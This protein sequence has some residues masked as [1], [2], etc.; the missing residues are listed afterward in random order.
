MFKITV[1]VVTAACKPHDN[2]DEIK[3]RYFIC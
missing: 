3:A 2:N 1:A